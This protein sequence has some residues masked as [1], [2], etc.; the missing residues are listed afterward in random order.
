MT[1][2]AMIATAMNANTTELIADKKCDEDTLD[3]GD[4]AGEVEEGAEI[5]EDTPGEFG[6]A[7]GAP[8][9]KH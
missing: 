8:G 3:F 5:G 6:E 1:S 4:A 7:L 9:G 2:H